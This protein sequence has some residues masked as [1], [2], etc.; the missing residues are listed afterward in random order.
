MFSKCWDIFFSRFL[1]F[2]REKT[3]KTLF[4]KLAAAVLLLTLLVMSEPAA[5]S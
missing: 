3:M 1:D 5:A 2:F 4:Y